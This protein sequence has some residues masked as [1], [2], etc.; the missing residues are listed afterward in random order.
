[1]VTADLE[2][3]GAGSDSLRNFA[4]VDEQIRST[5]ELIQ[6]GKMP[7][8]ETLVGKFL[9]W[10]F[11]AE[12]DEVREQEIDGSK[13]PDYQIVRRYLGPA[14]LYVQTEEDGWF[15]AGTLL[16]KDSGPLTARIADERKNTLRPARTRP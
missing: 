6:Q 5:Y 9:N 16:P 1:M 12:D 14:G 13:L 11:G 15:V 8:S 4:R 3:L 2:E 7:E 10:F